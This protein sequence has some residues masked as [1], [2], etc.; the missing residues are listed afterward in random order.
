LR[1][2]SHHEVDRPCVSVSDSSIETESSKDRITSE[3]VIARHYTSEDNGHLSTNDHLSK[4]Q[5]VFSNEK[6][7]DSSGSPAI[8][9][10]DDILEVHSSASPVSVGEDTSEQAVDK[11]TELNL[12]K[13]ESY[14]SDANNFTINERSLHQLD[15][16]LVASSVDMEPA[17]IEKLNYDDN[18]AIHYSPRQSSS[19]L[20]GSRLPTLAESAAY[21]FDESGLGHGTDKGHSSKVVAS[22]RQRKISA[23]RCELYRRLLSSEDSMKTSDVDCDIFDLQ[24]LSSSSDDDDDATDLN[25]D[26]NSDHSYLVHCLYVCYF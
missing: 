23:K 19:V 13:T 8:V 18:D 16:N 24:S 25:L 3:P 5:T 22:R 14:D 2:D 4:S 6:A 10:D 26:S 15:D 9:K 12:D 1:S 20:G 11:L 7:N 17:E 21:P